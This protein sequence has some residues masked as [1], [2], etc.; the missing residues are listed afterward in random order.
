MNVQTYILC[1]SQVPGIL[2]NHL[3][4]NDMMK[5]EGL[6]TSVI[7]QHIDFEFLDFCIIRVL[8][9][10]LEPNSDYFPVHMKILVLNP[11]SLHCKIC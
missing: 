1:I 3:V 11:G 7:I 8:P 2:C 5:A 6:N 9:V 4:I 10:W